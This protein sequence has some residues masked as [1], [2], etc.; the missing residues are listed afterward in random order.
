MSIGVAI[1]IAAIALAIMFALS[2]AAFAN[3]R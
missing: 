1:V 2:T 3:N